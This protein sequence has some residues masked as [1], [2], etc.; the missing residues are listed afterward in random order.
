MEINLEIDE[1]KLKSLDDLAIENYAEIQAALK[2][3]KAA[4]EKYRKILAKAVSDAKK[5]VGVD[6]TLPCKLSYFSAMYE[7]KVTLGTTKTLDQES[8]AEDW[9][10]MDDDFH[11]LFDVVEVFKP[12]T[13]LI[14]ELRS[15]L[16]EGEHLIFD[17]YVTEKPS[18]PTI[19]L[20]KP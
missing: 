18:L 3:I 12:K 2:K 1:K 5:S 7:I 8:I 10:D 17:N 19:S 4:E 16:K 9:P 11:R 15:S 20:E 13:A 14:K 6:V